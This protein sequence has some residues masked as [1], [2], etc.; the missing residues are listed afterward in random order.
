MTLLILLLLNNV[1]KAN[2]TLIWMVFG[3]CALIF[4]SL[5]T[6]LIIKRL[7]PALKGDIALELDN[8]GINDYVRDVS[9]G[10]KDIKDIKLIRGRSSSIM[11]INLKWESDY[12][13]Q[14]AIYLRWVRGSDSEIYKT[15]LACFEHNSEGFTT[16]PGS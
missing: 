16:D 9:I 11:Q 8:E 6:L 2:G 15:T 4:L 1:I 7:I 14:I 3:L 13:S 10:W 12:G 5:M